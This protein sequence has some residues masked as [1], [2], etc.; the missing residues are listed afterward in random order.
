MNFTSSSFSTSSL[1][2]LL[3]RTACTTLTLA[4]RSSPFVST[5]RPPLRSAS[6]VRGTTN[7]LFLCQPTSLLNP[8]ALSSNIGAVSHLSNVP[9]N[10]GPGRAPPKNRL[11]A[12]L[13]SL[14]T[15]GILLAGKG[16]YVL[17]A[18]KLTKFA[19]LG[20]MLA[21]VGTYS[22]FFGWPYAVGMVGLILV[23]ESGHALVMHR[24][25]IP[26]KPMVFI[27]F[28]GAAVAM[29]E[30]PRDAYDEALVAFGGPVLGS[31]GAAGV[32]AAGIAMQSNLLIALS[33]FGFM[34][35]LFN[36]LPIGMMDGGRI[37]GA[38]S[39]YAGM[40]GLGLGG[41]MIYNG[42]ISN[43]IFYLV[44][45]AG[46]YETFMKWYDPHAH[47][48][49]NY[50]AISGKQRAAITG[51]YFSLVAA[52]MAAMSVSSALKKSPEQL[53]RER[54]LGVYHPPGEWQ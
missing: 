54:Q 31:L 49:P 40:V 27:P 25:G 2:S 19:S 39:P 32:G 43:P 22:I 13:A 15:A 11:T 42:M 44:M 9:P 14:G 7:S 20:S 46:G 3:P 23:H 17:G 12:G 34:I 21:T 28:M 29:K 47:V 10:R 53:Q 48:P 26:F 50:Y 35:N 33:D 45:L 18:L 30:R 5:S 24:L 1:R 37:C 16:K 52:L 38:V 51:G 6:V 41:A 36:L 8:T 4:S